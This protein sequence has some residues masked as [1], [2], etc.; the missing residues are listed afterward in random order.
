MFNTCLLLLRIEVHVELRFVSVEKVRS[1]NG[2]VM[3][4]CHK[5]NSPFVS[6]GRY[7]TQ[8]D[9]MVGCA[10]SEFTLMK[11]FKTLETFQNSPSYISLIAFFC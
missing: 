10:G 7:P 8:D 4:M 11:G 5:S 3:W 1:Q 9:L 6:I 2:H